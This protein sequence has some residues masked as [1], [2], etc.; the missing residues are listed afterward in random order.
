ML[1]ILGVD[2]GCE[3]ES[4]EQGRSYM[5]KSIQISNCFFSRS[6]LF[7][8][9]GGVIFMDGG[10]YSMNI[11]YSMFN[12]CI[13]SDSGGAIFFFS[14]ISNIRMICANRCTCGQLYHF[15]YL[16]SVQVNQVEYLSVSNCSYSR[17][18][19]FAFALIQAFRDVTTQTLQ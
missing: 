18:G 9:L 5:D 8:G 7:S 19:F 6:S 17:S 4:I 12:N 10:S 2:V 15:A 16:Y 1:L 14:P 3:K 13:C 11:N